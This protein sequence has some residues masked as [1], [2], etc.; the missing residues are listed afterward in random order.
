MRSHVGK[1]PEKVSMESM[2]RP[3]IESNRGKRRGRLDKPSCTEIYGARFRGRGGGVKGS[4]SGVKGVKRDILTIRNKKMKVFMCLNVKN[5][6]KYIFHSYVFKTVCFPA[7]VNECAY[8]MSI[9][10]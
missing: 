8:C 2:K 9:C 6:L 10:P 5:I 3:K 1:W 7:C 4:R